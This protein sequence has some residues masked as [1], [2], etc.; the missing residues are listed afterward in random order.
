MDC[1]TNTKQ[2]IDLKFCLR[3]MEPYNTIEIM[4]IAA[5]SLCEA[6]NFSP[7]PRRIGIESHTALANSSFHS[8]IITFE[9]VHYVLL[10]ICNFSINCELEQSSTVQNWVKL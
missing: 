3:G 10:N 5:S 6:Q 4:S 7:H 8:V 1:Q 2:L 9:I